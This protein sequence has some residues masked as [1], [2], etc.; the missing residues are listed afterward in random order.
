ML[1]EVALTPDVFDGSLYSS[2][3]ACGI[4]LR[5]IREPLLG[6]VLVRNL[7]DGDW[8]KH[9]ANTS[10]G[11]WHLT[12]KELFKKLATQNRLRTFAVAGKD[13]PLNDDQWCDEAIV[14]D[15]VENLEVILAT[16]SVAANHS[17]CTLVHS[18]EKATNS[19]WW[20]GRSPSKMVP[21]NVAEYL[22]V[23]RLV[24]SHANSL[25][26]VDPHLDPSQPR[27]S[28]FIRLLLAAKRNPAA[29][30]EVHRCC[31]EGSGPSRQ[32]FTGAGRAELEQRFR[33][34]WHDPLKQ[35]GIRVSVFV[36]PDFHDRALI[37][38]LIG[39]RLS[40]GF[41]ESNDVNAS[42]T[43]SRL[44]KGDS[45]KIQRDFDEAVNKPHY[46]FQVP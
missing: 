6:E 5:Y 37:S 14:S 40:N 19:K 30:I 8:S 16:D 44:G 36:W 26:F 43:F 25:I 24:L 9:I 35:A 13:D 4:H 38:N 28:G 10:S 34:S 27:Y 20:Q 21:R 12:G 33:N 3:E 11:R 42:I 46:T 7:R 1:N 22:R 17:G 39:M 29:T 31:Y 23:L 15:T 45:E 41:D 18:I 2:Q 32:L